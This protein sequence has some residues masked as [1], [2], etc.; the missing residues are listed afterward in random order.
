MNT[1]IQFGTFR[2]AIALV[3]VL[4]VISIGCAPAE[5]QITVLEGTST[6]QMADE[7]LL[8]LDKLEPDLPSLDSPSVANAKDEKLPRPDGKPAT[9]DWPYFVETQKVPALPPRLCRPTTN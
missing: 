9:G 1:L 2:S 6:D 5:K 3:V 7:D 4:T 8:N